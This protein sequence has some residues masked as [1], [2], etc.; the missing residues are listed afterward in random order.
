[1]LKIEG[2]IKEQLKSEAEIKRDIRINKSRKI[3][4]GFYNSEVLEERYIS[5]FE[6][7]YKGEDTLFCDTEFLEKIMRLPI[8]NNNECK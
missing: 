3:R 8:K 5:S 6:V 4:F 1:M 2:K 7:D